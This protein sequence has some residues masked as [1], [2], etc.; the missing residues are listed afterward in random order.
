MRIKTNLSLFS[1]EL[2]LFSMAMFL[3]LYVA[4]NLTLLET[5]GTAIEPLEFSWTNIVIMASVFLLVSFV[6][7]RCVRMSR[8]LFVLFFFLIIFSGS[9]LLGAMIWSFPWNMIFALAVIAATIVWR[10]VFTHNIAIT[11]GLSGVAAVLGMSMTPTAALLILVLFSAY[12][13]VA[14]Y[15]TRH[16]MRMARTMLE[17]G[18]VFGFIIPAKWRDFLVHRDNAQ[19]GERFMLLGS[20]DIGLPIIFAASIARVSL[21]SAVVVAVSA[22]VGLLITHLLFVNQS[23]RRPMA[24]LPPIATMCVLGYLVASLL[25]Y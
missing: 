22:V 16:M 14:V 20:G 19:L 18:T 10:S 11:I 24:A 12:D 4:T 8:V 9:Q 13:I 3:G 21:L 1:K 5:A 2:L 23:Q 7:T 6:L 25:A 17:S 15:K